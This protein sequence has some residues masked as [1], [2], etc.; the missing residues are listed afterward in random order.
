LRAGTAYTWH[1]V[2]TRRSVAFPGF[3]DSLKDGKHAS[4]AQVFGELGYGVQAG[5]VRLEPFVNLAYVHVSSA[6]VNEKG[7]TAA[8]QGKSGSAGT[9][10]STLGVHASTA[11]D[12]GAARATARG[13][14]GW[15]HAFGGA[16]PDAR[17]SFAG[18]DAFMVA[19]VPVAKNAPVFD[20]GL[21]FKIGKNTTLGVSYN[22]QFGSGVRDNGVRATLNVMF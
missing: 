11:L 18:G 21:D 16:T 3:T 2:S 7:G 1:D 12:L 19:G 20:A 14:L 10:F 17:L 13:T 9:A 8:L 22:G 6:S 4:T 15:R 5:A